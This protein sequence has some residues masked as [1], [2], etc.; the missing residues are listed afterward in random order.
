MEP[1]DGEYH[2]AVDDK[3]LE[4]PAERAVVIGIVSVYDRG[5]RLECRELVLELVCII[6]SGP[7]FHFA[8]L[9]S[10]FPECENSNCLSWSPMGRLNHRNLHL[11]GL[12]W[13]FLL[14]VVRNHYCFG[15]GVSGVLEGYSS[16]G[17]RDLPYLPY[18][19]GLP[20][21]PI[22]SKTWLAVE[23][24]NKKTVGATN[25]FQDCHEEDLTSSCV[26]SF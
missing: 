23:A 24:E 16:G 26:S 13:C 18:L 8:E 9:I 7:V 15:K 10:H 12:E 4:L 22:P 2:Y 25:G 21:F 5:S 19:A 3:A 14:R 6:Y 17:F 20:Y 11:I 1:G